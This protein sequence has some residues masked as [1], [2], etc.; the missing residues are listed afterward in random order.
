MDN[1]II[2]DGKIYSLTADKHEKVSFLM[3]AGNDTV[4]NVMSL[5]GVKRCIRDAVKV[6]DAS[7]IHPHHP[8]CVDEKFFFPG[9][10]VDEPAPCE[11][12]QEGETQEEPEE[13][14]QPKHHGFGKKRK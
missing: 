5:E 7:D 4:R 10:S 9:E 2:R 6:T 11:V 8:I 13:T 1:T 12:P 3:Q 14:P